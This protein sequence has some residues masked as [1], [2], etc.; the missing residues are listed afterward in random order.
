MNMK[1]RRSSRSHSWQRFTGGAPHQRSNRRE[2][3]SAF[4]VYGCEAVEVG[5]QP[6][7]VYLLRLLLSGI[8]QMAIRTVNQA[9][10]FI[11]NRMVS[12]C[13]RESPGAVAR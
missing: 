7:V 4:L 6:A 11:Q 8:T 12:N 9:I 1:R 3:C 5:Q 10:E 13:A 2:K